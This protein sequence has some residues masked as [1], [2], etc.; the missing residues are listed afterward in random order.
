MQW[1]NT[2]DDRLRLAPV[3]VGDEVFALSDR[4]AVMYDGRVVGTVTPDIPR[5]DIGLL[6]AG[7]QPSKG[8]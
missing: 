6:M 5:E 4:I 8:A 7:A 1:H 2:G 3:V